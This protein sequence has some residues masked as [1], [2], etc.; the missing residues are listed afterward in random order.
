M[1]D[2][3]KIIIAILI[4]SLQCDYSALLIVV[5][6]DFDLIVLL[7]L[8]LSLFIRI[9]SSKILLIIVVCMM[10]YSVGRI[11]VSYDIVQ[12]WRSLV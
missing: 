5:I 2:W 9:K 7:N 8:S 4:W 12:F 11:C 1:I 10:F 6:I 3:F